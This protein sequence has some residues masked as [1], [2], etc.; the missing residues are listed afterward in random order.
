MA[1]MHFTGTTAMKNVIRVIPNLGEASGMLS[2]YAKKPRL[3][4]IARA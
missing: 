4:L 3:D 2:T 1:L